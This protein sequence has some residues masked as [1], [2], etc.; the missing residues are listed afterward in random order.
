MSGVVLLGRGRAGDREQGLA[1]KGQQQQL[2]TAN[3]S[4]ASQHAISHPRLNQ[5]ACPAET[6]RA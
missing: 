1:C 5:A 2:H 4:T 3:A 6:C